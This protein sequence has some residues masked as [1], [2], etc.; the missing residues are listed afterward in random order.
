MWTKIAKVKKKSLL[1]M[2]TVNKEE[3]L[4]LENGIEISSATGNTNIIRI[5]IN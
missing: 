5:T 1:K 2:F 3:R 4:H